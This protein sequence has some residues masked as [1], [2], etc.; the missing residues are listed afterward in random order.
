MSVPPNRSAF[1][2]EKGNCRQQDILTKKE[3]SQKDKLE[4]KKVIGFYYK[5]NA[6]K[7]D[8]NHAMPPPIIAWYQLS[9]AFW[10]FP[11]SRSLLLSPTW[12]F[13]R[14]VTICGRYI[15]SA[16]DEK[17]SLFRKYLITLGYTLETCQK[18]VF[19]IPIFNASYFCLSNRGISSR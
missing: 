16:A 1:H 15:K 18:P 10:G 3:T 19:K 17:G 6:Y 4:Q 2:P 12:Q 9:Q 14:L 8:L 11:F 13:P 7:C 5:R